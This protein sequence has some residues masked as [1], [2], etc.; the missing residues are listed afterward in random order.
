MLYL[1]VESRSKKK[2]SW[3]DWDINIVDFLPSIRYGQQIGKL[4]TPQLILRVGT[5]L[6]MSDG[7]LPKRNVFGAI[8]SAVKK[9]R[10]RKYKEPVDF[11]K[12]TPGCLTNRE[13]LEIDDA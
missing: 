5:L 8:K 1:P 7:R 6:R 3:H 12:A 4:Y 10:G 9:G 2:K 11:V 13:W